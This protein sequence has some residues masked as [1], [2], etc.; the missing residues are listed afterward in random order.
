MNVWRVIGLVSL[1]A[2]LAGCGVLPAEMTVFPDKTAVPDNQAA[3]EVIT[4]ETSARRLLLTE[5]DAIFLGE[6]TYVSEPFWVDG[7]PY[8]HV[9]VSVRQALVD[10]VDLSSGGIVTMAARANPEGSGAMQTPQPFVAPLQVGDARVFFVKLV[11]MEGENGRSAVLTLL[12]MPDQTYM[13][14][15]EFEALAAELAQV[16]PLPD[17]QQSAY[18]ELGAY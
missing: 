10:E 6:L 11:E 18:D 3:L 14:A 8:H 2:L 1:V 16:R 12:P 4:D 13:P 15:S 5:A 17:Q 7:Q 9:G